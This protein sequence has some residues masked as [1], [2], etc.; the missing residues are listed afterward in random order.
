MFRESATPEVDQ[1]SA[2]ISRAPASR[3]DERTGSPAEKG[4]ATVRRR[5]GE[6]RAA[7]LDQIR[8]QMADGTLV[9]RQMTVAEHQTA[10]QAAA[11]HLHGKRGAASKAKRSANAGRDRLSPPRPGG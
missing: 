7:R 3:R 10:L 11:A 1:L 2:T 5:K 8:A 4:A 9:V 6:R